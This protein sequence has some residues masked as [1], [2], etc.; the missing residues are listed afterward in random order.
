MSENN[1]NR[2]PQKDVGKGN[3]SLMRWVGRLVLFAIILAITS[4]LTPG[5]SI[6]GFWTFVLASV[7]ITGL[8]Y[9]VESFMKVDASPFGKGLKGFI[10]SAVIIYLA[11]FL[12]P[13]MR[14]S[15]IGAILASL[16]IGVIDAII[17][18]RSM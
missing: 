8:D 10:I 13:N 18:S 4:F 6:R 11:Q 2:E 1:S 3:N 7:V 15:I 12:V 16:V 17:P 14:V 5:F 9:L